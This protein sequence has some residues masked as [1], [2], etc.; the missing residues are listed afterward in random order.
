MLNGRI[1]KGIG[2]FYYVDTEQGCMNVEQEEFLE[3][4][5]NSF[6]R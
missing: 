6:S 1:M 4:I 2:G 3:K 5:N